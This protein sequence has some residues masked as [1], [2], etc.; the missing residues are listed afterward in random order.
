MGL[1]RWF[2]VKSARISTSTFTVTSPFFIPMLKR[3]LSLFQSTPQSAEQNS[4]AE[5]SSTPPQ[6]LEAPGVAPLD[7]ESTLIVEHGLPVPDWQQVQHWVDQIAEDDARGKAW[8][9]AEVAWLVHL[10]A[11]LGP[12]YRLVRRGSAVVLSSLDGVEAVAAAQFMNATQERIVS[13]LD[14]VARAPEG[15]GYDILLVLDDEDTYYNYVARYYAEDGEFAFSGGMFI[16][17]GCGHFVTRKAKELKDVEPVIVH[18]LTHG[19]LSHLPIP[20]WLNEGLAVNTE[21]RLSPGQAK[22]H[23]ARQR[24]VLHRK[25]WNAQT[26]QEFWSGHSYSRPDEGNMLSYDLGRLLVQHLSSDWQR[27]AAFANA[28]HADDGGLAAARDILGVE[29]GELVKALF[30][31]PEP[32]PS[33]SPQAALWRGSGVATETG[34]AS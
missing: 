10:R 27:F 22:T 4:A 31:V 29:L 13:V 20:L 8:S 7:F 21:E 15:A 11:A 14:G 5:A 28:A 25:F 19:S 26:I 34:H 3:L 33:W 24:D 16:S 32:A 23:T 12:Q 17:H 2:G 18:E 9:E 30:E 6:F 1:W